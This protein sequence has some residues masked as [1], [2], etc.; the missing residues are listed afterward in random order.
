LPGSFVGTV[1]HPD[2]E[3]TYAHHQ[4]EEWALGHFAEEVR[5]AVFGALEEGRTTWAVHENDRSFSG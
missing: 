1:D 5:T 3:A 2:A 4:V